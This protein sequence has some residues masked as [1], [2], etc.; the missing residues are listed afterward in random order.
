MQL[1]SKESEIVTQSK[2]DVAPVAYLKMTSLELVDKLEIPDN[3][4]LLPMLTSSQWK[5]M[6]KIE[7]SES[8]KVSS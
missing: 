3:I 2:D 5:D 4:S 1:F 8:H 7:E 6:Y